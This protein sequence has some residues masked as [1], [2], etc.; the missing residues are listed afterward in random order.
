LVWAAF[1]LGEVFALRY[2]LGYI[3][4]IV[5]TAANDKPIGGSVLPV[6]F[7]NSAVLLAIIGVSLYAVGIWR[8]DLS[9]KKSRMDIGA[10]VVLFTS[11][12]LLWH[13]A[14]AVF[15]G[16]VSLG[17]LLAVNIE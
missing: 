4:N 2:L 5:P 10:L 1:G 6:L 13:T 7:F 12:F 11:G 14:L 15:P 8:V 3:V 17:Y 9:T 16:L